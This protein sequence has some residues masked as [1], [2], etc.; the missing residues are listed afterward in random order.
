[1]HATAADGGV[2]GIIERAIC[3][4]RIDGDISR[5]GRRATVE[6]GRGQVAVYLGHVV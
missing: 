3:L 2:I 1:V 4:F 6:I 5:R